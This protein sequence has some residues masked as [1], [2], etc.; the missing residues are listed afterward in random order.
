[1]TRSTNHHRVQTAAP[2]CLGLVLVLALVGC[3]SPHPYVDPAM[4]TAEY[5]ALV[6]PAAP[7]PVALDVTFQANGKHKRAVD[8]Q[9][10]AAV[11]KALVRSG[12][13][14]PGVGSDAAA[15]R[16]SIVINNVGDVAGAAASGFGTGLTLGAVGTMV[17]DGYVM[18]VQHSRDGGA[19]TTREYRHAIVTTIGNHAP[20]PGMAPM[21]DLNTAF[22]RV[23]EDM[24]LRMLADLQSSG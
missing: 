5:D 14:A 4:R 24:T 9:A 16:L 20:P 3:V 12:V 19:A 6:R 7:R 8:P 13:Y 18:T 15:E 22:D 17:T 10:R 2:R 11:E 23:V 1:M 21:K